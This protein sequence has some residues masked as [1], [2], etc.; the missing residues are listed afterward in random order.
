MTFFKPGQIRLY[1]KLLRFNHWIKN[2]LIF[3]PL[4][5][6]GKAF[7]LYELEKTILLFFAFGFIA[8]AVYII[9]DVLDRHADASHPTKK[10]RPIASK[11]ITHTNALKLAIVLLALS[12]LLSFFFP[13][14]TNLLLLTYF[15]LN[16]IYSYWLK[17]LPVVDLFVITSMYILRITA[18]AALFGVV[19]SHWLMLCTFFLALFLITAKRRA[20]YGHAGEENGKTRKVLALYNKTFLDHLLTI[21]T[22]ATL[23]L[24]SLYVI[25]VDKPYIIFSIMIASFG[26]FRYLYIVYQYNKGESPEIVMIQ[27]KVIFITIITWVLYLGVMFYYF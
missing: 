26:I 3:T 10:L 8:S 16:L 2:L 18:G 14:T 17:T 13:L 27:D 21:T 11:K 12:L 19:I 15:C 4:F 1:L 5:F 22:T 6:A 7:Q 23:V 20:E 24:Y 25:S 9:N